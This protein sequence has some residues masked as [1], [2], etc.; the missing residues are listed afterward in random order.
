MGMVER[1]GVETR[2]DQSGKMGHVDH[3]I[4]TDFVGDLPE[5]G[6][7]NDPRI[8]RPAGDDDSR[9]LG[10]RPGADIVVID[11][12]ILPPHPV[13]TRREPFARLIDRRTMGEMPAF[14]KTHPQK[15]IARLHQRHEHGLIGLAA[16]MRLDIGKA[17]R[18]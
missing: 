14:G 11:A 3:Q 2:R 6:K 12:A 1:I 5:S 18:E 10:L 16:G 13:M 15:D 7:I 4:R 8:A 9:P 17:G